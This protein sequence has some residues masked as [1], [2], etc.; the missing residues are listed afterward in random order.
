MD[1]IHHGS[2]DNVA[3]DKFIHIGNL[4]ISPPPPLF[5]T[6]Q[7][8]DLLRM[9]PDKSAS[10]HVSAINGDN[11]AILLGRQIFQALFESGY[12]NLKGVHSVFVPL[13]EGVQVR[14]EP[15][16]EYVVLIGVI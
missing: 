5:T 1:Q 11:R 8:K 4:N 16:G 2:G 3:G 9:L 14:Q 7:M 12:T 6:E 10:T 13:I 15:S